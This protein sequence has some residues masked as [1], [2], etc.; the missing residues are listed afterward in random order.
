MKKALRPIL[1]ILAIIIV[2]VAGAYFYEQKWGLE[3]PFPDHH[4]H[5][6]DGHN[7]D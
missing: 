2:L 5:S 6:G 1:L 3:G 7:H 4:H